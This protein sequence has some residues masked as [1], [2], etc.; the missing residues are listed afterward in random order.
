LL[1]N[2]LTLDEA[3]TELDV[4]RNTVKSHLSAVF[5]KTGVNRQTQLVQLIL[6]SV[7]PL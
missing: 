5:A 2:G 6:K 4:S 7:G 3:A 1:A